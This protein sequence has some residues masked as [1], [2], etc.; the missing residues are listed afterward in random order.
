[1]LRFLEGYS[2]Q[3]I[4]ELLGTSVGTVAVVLHRTR[5]RLQRDIAAV[6]G[7]N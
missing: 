2:N 3:E 5:G 6:F 4:A 7:G 1:M